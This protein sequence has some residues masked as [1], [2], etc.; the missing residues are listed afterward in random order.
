MPEY[1]ID[2]SPQ[3][4][5][6]SQLQMMFAICHPAISAEAQI[7]LSLRIFCGFGIEEIAD[8]FLTNKE[9]INKRLFRAKEKL[10][11][12]KIRIELPG[13]QKLM[14]GW[15]LCSPPF[16]CYSV[17]DIIPSATIKRCEKNYALKPCGYVICWWKMN[18][19]TNRP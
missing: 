16:I 18:T 12:E 17:K 3:N 13:P 15:P 7:G 8:A 2:L 14:N 10:R 19:P 5:N 4:I 1:D 6:D 11:E 9:T